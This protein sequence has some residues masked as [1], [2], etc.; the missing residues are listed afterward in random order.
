MTER[1]RSRAFRAGMSKGALSPEEVR[2]FE[3]KRSAWWPD[4]LR[5]VLLA[6]MLYWGACSLAMGIRH[7]ELTQMQ[8]FLNTPRAVLW[9]EP[10]VS[11]AE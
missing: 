8:L 11:D 2:A 4:A 3:G 9:M 1:G 5:W 6:A 7:P 10:E